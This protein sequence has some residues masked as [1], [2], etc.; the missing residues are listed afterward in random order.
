MFSQKIDSGSSGLQNNAPNYGNQAGRDMYLTTEKKLTSEE[1][2][3]V[4]KEINRLSTTNNIKCVGY[5]MGQG[6]NGGEVLYQIKQA[7]TAAGYDPNN[8]LM[9]TSSGNWEGLEI[10]VQMNCITVFIGHF[11]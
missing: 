2:D 4:I 9:G 8:S 6:N 1:L 10:K 5:L 11:Q 3:M 7:V